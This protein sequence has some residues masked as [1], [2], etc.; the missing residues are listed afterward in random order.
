MIPNKIVTIFISII[1]A[2]GTIYVSVLTWNA[3][4]IHDYIGIS[5][6]QR[7]SIT[8]TGEGKVTSVPDIAKIQLGYKIEKR[9]VAEAQEDNT[10]KMNAMIKK[11]KEDFKIDE[12]DIKTTTYNISPRY[13]WNRGKQTL[14]GYEVRQNISVKVREMEKVSQIL[15]SAGGIGLNQVG[16]LTFEID[17]PEELKQEAREKALKAAKEKAEALAKVAGVKLGRIISFS[18]SGSQPV[19]IYRD[20]AMKTEGLGG[21]EVP[22]I[23]AGSTE[24]IIVATVEYEIL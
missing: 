8:V 13:D 18:E 7:H 14:R 3:I 6:E 12:K 10:E 19:P 4:K 23:E 20:Y 5:E 24:I 1:L 2:I 22:E 15:D 11:L 17:D 16:S 21:A 9:T